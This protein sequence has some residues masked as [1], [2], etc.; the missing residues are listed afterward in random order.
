MNRRSQVIRHAAILALAGLALTGCETIR[1]AAGKAKSPP[2]EF[3]VV[4]KA[5]LVIPPDYNLRPPN[6]GAAPTNQVSPTQSAEQALFPEDTQTAAADFKG[7][8]SMGER[9]LLA[10]ANAQNANPGIR[11]E[12]RADEKSMEPADES[13]TDK[14]LYGK[15]ED[16]GHPVDADAVIDKNTSVKPSDK[17]SDDD[18][19]WFD[20]F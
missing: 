15:P 6:P 2:D 11:E 19:G 1:D 20:W 3:A 5:P 16:N 9:L 4:T 14:V 7:D 13:F 18:G 17:K 10:N 8:F 12:L